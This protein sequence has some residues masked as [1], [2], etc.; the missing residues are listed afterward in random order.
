MNRLADCLGHLL[1]LVWETTKT[2][3]P[4]LLERLPV[5]RRDAQVQGGDPPYSPR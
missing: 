1:D 3:L 2:A 5:A 4:D